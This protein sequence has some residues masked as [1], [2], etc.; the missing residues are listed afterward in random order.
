MLWTNSLTSG[1]AP[2]PSVSVPKSDSRCVRA[3]WKINANGITSADGV[4]VLAKFLAQ[5]RRLDAYDGISNRIE[6]SGRP[7]TSTPML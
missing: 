2:S 4:V 1:A 5:P 3:L 6:G 7:K